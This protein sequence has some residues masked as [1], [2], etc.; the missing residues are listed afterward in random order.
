MIAYVDL[1]R[2]ETAQ[3]HR[4]THKIFETVT[5]ERIGLKDKERVSK[6]RMILVTATKY[7]H[8]K[9]WPHAKCLFK[10]LEPWDTRF[11]TPAAGPAMAA[12]F[13]STGDV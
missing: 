2:A 3:T 7:T 6:Q 5:R 12:L 13:N 4:Q 1:L 11:G 8:L 10:S 9:K